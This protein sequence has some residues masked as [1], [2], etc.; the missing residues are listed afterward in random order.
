MRR[1]RGKDLAPF[2]PEPEKTLR[3]RSKS[4]RKGK[5]MA[6][7]DL[8][9]ELDEALEQIMLRDEALENERRLANER[10][11][12]TRREIEEIRQALVQR[13]LTSY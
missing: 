2:D 7:R 13:E 6:G 12:A 11:E 9:A 5:E 1:S 8:Q 10:Q 3:S 4:I